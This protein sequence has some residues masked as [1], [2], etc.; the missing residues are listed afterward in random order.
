LLCRPGTSP[1]SRRVQNSAGPG[2][3]SPTG[4]SGTWRTPAAT[5]RLWCWCW[6]WC[7]SSAHPRRI[8]LGAGARLP[9][10][11]AGHRHEGQ[12]SQRPA[13]HQPGWGGAQER[14]LLLA[15][16]SIAR[17][18]RWTST[19]SRCMSSSTPRPRRRRRL[20]EREGCAAQVGPCQ[21]NSHPG[22]LRPPVRGRA[23]RRRG[24]PGSASCGAPRGLDTVTPFTQ[25]GPLAL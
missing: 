11:K 3:T 23:G 10:R 5:S 16:S 20:G 18:D 6:C 25:E 4:S 7:S 24:P 21:R 8:S 13:V 9:S 14:Q 22:P 2:V 17:P 12:G 1:Q 19:R 15:T